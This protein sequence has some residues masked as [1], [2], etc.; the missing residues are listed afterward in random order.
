MA[1]AKAGDA[2]SF[3]ALARRYEKR[4]FNYALRMLGNAQDAEDVFQDTLLRLHRHRGRYRE[5]APLRP[6]LYRIATNL[7]RD[8]LRRRMRRSWVSLDAP[9]AAEGG[10]ALG[11]LLPAA[12]PGADAGAREAETGERLAA[13]VAALPVKHRTVFLM[14]RYEELPYAEIAKALR[15][16]VGTVKSRMNKAVKLLLAQ[17]EDTQA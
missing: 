15:I 9:A 2:A 1:H 8:H 14:A 3:E 10:A 16:P 6:W 5:G 11:D 17:L 12:G 4:L 13:A 7:C